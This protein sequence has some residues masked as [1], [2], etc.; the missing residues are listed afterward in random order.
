MCFLIL[1]KKLSRDLKKSCYLN[2]FLYY[3]LCKYLVSIKNFN[4]VVKLLIMPIQFY[5]LS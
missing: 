3:R 1:K 5:I 2:V 4:Y